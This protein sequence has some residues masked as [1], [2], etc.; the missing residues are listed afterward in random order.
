MPG[1]AVIKEDQAFEAAATIFDCLNKIQEDL[2]LEPPQM[3]VPIA[4][5][6]ICMARRSVKRDEILTWISGTLDAI[7]KGGDLEW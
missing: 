7:K 3:T 2:G 1:L 4:M 5:A 6:I